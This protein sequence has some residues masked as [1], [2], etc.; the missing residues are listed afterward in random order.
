MDKVKTSHQILH[1][2]CVKPGYRFESQH[3]REEVILVLRAHP[4][5]QL[6]WII[7]SIVF[8]IVLIIL[9]FFLP[10]VLNPA[11]IFFAN[12]FGFAVIFA[13]IWFNFLGWFFNVGIITNERIIDVDFHSVLYKEVTEAQLGKVEDVTAK[14]GGFFASVFNYGNVFVQTAG[15]EVNIEFYNVP[16][17]SE[18]TKIINQLVPK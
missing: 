7:N 17:P 14:S 1:A 12:V 15:T 4:V 2:F 16:K 3:T 5:T 18:V 8:L 6:P 11:Q 9:N 10:S 13:Y